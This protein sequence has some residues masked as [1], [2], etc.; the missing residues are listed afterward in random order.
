MAVHAIFL[1]ASAADP[2]TLIVL[3]DENHLANTDS[4]LTTLTTE[5]A[6]GDILVWALGTNST[7]ANAISSF[8][9][10]VKP[11]N[12]NLFI[13]GPFESNVHWVWAGIVGNMAS[14][15]EEA[16]NIEYVVNGQ[17]YTKDP[18]LRMKT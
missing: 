16:Y 1:Y 12:P 17:S 6:P 10:S 2:D 4:G 14:G 11:G 9:L 13:Q 3:D 15:T 18:K 5:I 8:S 7:A